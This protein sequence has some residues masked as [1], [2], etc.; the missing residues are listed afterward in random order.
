MRNPEVE[1]DRETVVAF[2]ESDQPDG[3]SEAA[4]ATFQ[5]KMVENGLTDTLNEL[6]SAFADPDDPDGGRWTT[7]DSR[8]QRGALWKAAT[9][10]TSSVD[11]DDASTMGST[12]VDALAVGTQN[13]VDKVEDGPEANALDERVQMATRLL[14]DGLKADGPEQFETGLA[15]LQEIAKDARSASGADALTDL[16]DDHTSGNGGLLAAFRNPAVPTPGRPNGFKDYGTGGTSV[17]ARHW[18]QIDVGDPT[19]DRAMAFAT[20]VA[21]VHTNGREWRSAA[22]DLSPEGIERRED[23]YY[24]RGA[25]MTEEEG[26]SEEEADQ[27]IAEMRAQELNDPDITAMT[28]FVQRR[29][30]GWSEEFHAAEEFSRDISDTGKHMVFM[31]LRDND[32]ATL[33]AGRGVMNGAKTFL[34]EFV[35]NDEST[36]TVTTAFS[37]NGGS[38]RWPDAGENPTNVAD[39]RLNAMQEAGRTFFKEESDLQPEATRFLAHSMVTHD[40][41]QAAGQN[42]G[43]LTELGSQ[44][45]TLAA[46]MRRVSDRML[47][48][49]G[50]PVTE[51]A[52]DALTNQDR[53]GAVSAYQAMGKSQTA[54][55]AA[56]FVDDLVREEREGTAASRPE[57]DPTLDRLREAI[58]EIADG[59]ESSDRR[60]DTGK[61]D[62]LRTMAVPGELERRLEIAQKHRQWRPLTSG[63]LEL[64]HFG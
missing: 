62:R 52:V 51:R 2:D 56:A 8:E 36:D 64:R 30:E 47:Q 45:G 63:D 4:S 3:P 35:T 41:L 16:T 34:D 26:L 17:W 12:L 19:D 57:A 5:E 43:Y 48:Q 10:T 46:D 40:R 60:F 14:R 38:A 58:V 23:S 29:G 11:K 59:Y 1:L 18:S 22:Y 20:Q 32:E 13:A 27:A 44:D 50:D 15:M 39:H 42:M 33:A 7:L 61:I 53:E 28:Q 49:A 54:M 6:A 37:A 21:R 25:W 31:G 9:D 55:V 24:R